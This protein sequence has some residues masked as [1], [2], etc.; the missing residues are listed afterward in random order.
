MSTRDNRR[1]RSKRRK[2]YRQTMMIVNLSVVL[3]T[4]TLV[5]IGLFH[6]FTN[7]KEYRDIGIELY[8]QGRYEEAIGYF[9]KAL[10]C[11]Q[12]FSDSVNVDIELYKA[13]CYLRM[14]NFMSAGETYSKIAAK[15]SKRHYN[16]DDINFL[17]S[18]CVSLEKFSN[19]DYVSTVANFVQAV[20]KGYTEI[21]IYAAICY[22]NQ[23]N[24]NKMKEYFDIYV[25][26][27]GMNSYLYYKYA[28]YYILQENYETAFSYITQGLSSSDTSYLRQIKYVQIKC[29]AETGNY[30]YAY[31]LAKEYIAEYPDDE[32]GLDMYAYLD[33]RVNLNTAPVNDIFGIESEPD[34][35]SE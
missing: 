16:P 20:D 31:E 35:D 13:D 34:V 10:K 7:K 24:Y 14:E 27:F 5:I 2:A 8:E 4:V 22:E 12:W 3:L 1:R 26:K 17:T 11:N 28:S 33:T 9:D 23:R 18:L 15:Y 29:Y 19:G 21:S 25:Q 32:N 30:Q 6:I